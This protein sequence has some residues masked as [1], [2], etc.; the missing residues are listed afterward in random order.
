[1]ETF[2]P[3]FGYGGSLE[4]FE[5]AAAKG[6]EESLWLL[7][8]V[9]GLEMDPRAFKEAFARTEEPLGLYFAGLLSDYWSRDRFVLMKKSAEGG[10]SWGQMQYRY[11][12]KNGDSGFVEKDET[13]EMEWL[14]KAE[15]QQNPEAMYWLANRFR[16]RKGDL[17]KA[18]SFHL[19]AAELGWKDSMCSVSEMLRDG[20]GCENN[21]RQAVI[22]STKGN[23]SVI[24]K[25]L[26]EAREAFEGGLMMDAWGCDF[27]QLCYALGWGLYWRKYGTKEWEGRSGQEKEFGEHCLDYYCSC[28]E[29]QQKSI[30]T[31]LGFW[32]G[33]FGV[34]EVGVM[35]AELVWEGREENL[36]KGFQL[37]E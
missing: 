9:G 22:W 14:Q 13:E 11:Y 32:K 18:V 31:F 16:W 23:W 5:R 25:V 10:C 21:L 3:H 6:H 35:I 33:S 36:V 2:N 27:N 15:R 1:M 24:W 34:K 37:S 26:E 29:L 12:F 7:S 19:A 4:H 8:V 30:F 28:V 20:E 17:S